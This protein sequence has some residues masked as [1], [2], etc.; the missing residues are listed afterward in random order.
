MHRP[1]TF[2][3][4][5]EDLRSDPSTQEERVGWVTARLLDRLAELGVV[6]T[7]FCVADVAARHPELV[8]RMVADGHELGVHGLT[9]TPND[10]LTPSQFTEQIRAAKAMLEDLGGEPVALYRAPQ[11]S[12][13]PETAWVPAILTELGFVASSSVLPA[14]SPLYGWPGAPMTPFRW[15]SGLVELPAPVTRFGPSMIPFLGGAYLRVLPGRVRRRGIDRSDPSVVLWTYCHP[16]EFDPDEPFYVFEDGGWVASRVGWFNRRNM[17]K[18]V[19][20]VILPSAGP[21]LGD[22]VA[23]LGE[24]PTFDPATVPAPSAPSRFQG[25]L[26]TRAKARGR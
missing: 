20:S 18:R 11:Y 16:W 13:V 19:E 8:A 1:V 7:I 2:S 25:T 6:G 22:L 12:L 21:R 26:R 23:T 10:L 9:H 4:D 24:L 17:M 5:F 15:P 14:K 3:L